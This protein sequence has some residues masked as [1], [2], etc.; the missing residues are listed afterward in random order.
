MSL[1]CSCKGVVVQ[2]K[3]VVTGVV[4]KVVVGKVVVE[5]KAVVEDMVDGILG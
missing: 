5:D 3:V 1:D 4:G 2:D